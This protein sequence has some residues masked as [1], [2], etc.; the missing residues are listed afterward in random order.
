MLSKKIRKI[1]CKVILFGMMFFTTIIP[2]KTFAAGK[3]IYNKEEADWCARNGIEYKA[4]DKRVFRKDE[5]C[6]EI[7]LI[8]CRITNGHSMVFKSIF[9]L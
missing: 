3:K 1:L 5:Y 6:Y 7:P 9:L 8:H 4:E 2:I